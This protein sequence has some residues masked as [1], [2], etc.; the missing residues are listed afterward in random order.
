[1]FDG[2]INQRDLDLR[3]LRMF[4]A[5]VESP[6]LRVAADRLYITQQALSSTIRELERNLGVALFSRSRRSLALTEAGE[7]L[8][9]GA[10]PLLAGGDHLIHDVRRAESGGPKPF[11]IGHAPDLATSEVF[12]LIESVVLANPSVPITVRPIFAEQIRDELMSGSVDLALGRGY[13][14]PPELAATV[15]A[16]HTLRLA[17]HA[18]N[19][20]AQRDRVELTELADQEIVVWGEERETEYT[21]ILASICRRAGFEPRII[22]S[23]LLGTPPHTAVIAHPGACAFVTNRPGWIYVNRIRIIEF[24]DPPT[25]PVLA[26]WLPHTSS[27]L[28]NTILASVV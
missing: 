13:Q 16:N 14:S 6:S 3:R 2:G 15:A 24:V 17:V 26:M 1:M 9:Q 25:A 18:D 19:P 27:E 21:T 23:N 20:L 12:A 28:R 8:Y 7:V 11:V 10:V 4:V 22:V 5:V